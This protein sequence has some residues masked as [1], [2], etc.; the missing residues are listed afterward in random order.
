[1]YSRAKPSPP[2]A[3]ARA[4]RR[5]E[6]ANLTISFYLVEA[7]YTRVLT[8]PTPGKAFTDRYRLFEPVHR[9]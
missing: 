7:Q 9:S 4:K 3:T 6:P 2:I 1:M 8:A 5:R